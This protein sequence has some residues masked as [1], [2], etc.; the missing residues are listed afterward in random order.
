[1]SSNSNL[2]TLIMKNLKLFKLKGN[3][4]DLEKGKIYLFKNV[5]TLNGLYVIELAEVFAMFP[6]RLITKEPI[7]FLVH[8]KDEFLSNFEYITLQQAKDEI[9]NTQAL[10]NREIF[11]R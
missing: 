7:P 6:D 5:D 8:N 1:M 4:N 2:S 11:R 3:L 9:D 10:L